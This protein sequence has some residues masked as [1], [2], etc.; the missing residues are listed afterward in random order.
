MD[1]QNRKMRTPHRRFHPISSLPRRTQFYFEFRSACFFPLNSALCFAACA[2]A[3]AL[4][5]LVR[6]SLAFSCSLALSRGLFCNLFWPLSFSSLYPLLRCLERWSIERVFVFLFVGLI[7]E[8]MRSGSRID[9]ANFF[10]G[11]GWI[12]FGSFLSVSEILFLGPC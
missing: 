3:R 12:C 6:R 8:C 1:E 9:S 5:L 7:C 10:G 4:S 11:Y 2:R